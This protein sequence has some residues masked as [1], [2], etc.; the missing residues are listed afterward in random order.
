MST[1][2]RNVPPVLREG[3]LLATPLDSPDLICLDLKNGEPKWTVS[4]AILCL[5]VDSLRGKGV[6]DHLVGVSNRRVILGGRRVAA[7]EPPAGGLG[8]RAP[9]R[10]AWAFPAG[11]SQP[12][13]AVLAQ[14]LITGSTILIPDTRE[15]VELDARTGRRTGILQWPDDGNLLV[16]E[17][18]S[19]TENFLLLLVLV[20]A[21]HLQ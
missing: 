7:F 9:R 19:Y 16:E 12:L 4:N 8:M 17:G 14:P 20:G 18:V 3:L 5:G 21:G 11:T 6:L 10:L 15:L 13:G 1:V 2:W